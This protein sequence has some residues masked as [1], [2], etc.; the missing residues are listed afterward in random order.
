MIIFVINYLA[1]TALYQAYL[2][3]L[4]MSVIFGSLTKS[5]LFLV[6]KNL[7]ALN[8]NLQNIPWFSWCYLNSLVLNSQ[9]FFP[10]ICIEALVKSQHPD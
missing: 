3:F 5:P 9:L 4:Q 6:E 10:Q 8:A 2:F 1:S 7:Q